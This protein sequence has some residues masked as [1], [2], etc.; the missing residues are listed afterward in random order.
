MDHNKPTIQ[1][2]EDLCIGFIDYEKAFDSIE[3][4]DLFLFSSTERNGYT[5]NERYIIC[6]LKDIHTDAT[7]LNHLDSD[8]SE[9]V[10]ISRRRLDKEILCHQMC[11]RQLWRLS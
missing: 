3:H 9:I 4:P 5:V 1:K 7:S 8:V 10:K 2:K 11:L 6:I